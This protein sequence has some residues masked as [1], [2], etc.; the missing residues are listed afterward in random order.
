MWVGY[1]SP[2]DRLSGPSVMASGSSFQ[3]A[4][5]VC[6]D[7][8]RSDNEGRGGAGGVEVTGAL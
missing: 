5:M 8:H 7:T 3:G 6:G 4:T 2:L 1:K